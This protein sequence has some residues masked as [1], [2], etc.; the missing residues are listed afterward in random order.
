MHHAGLHG[1]LGPG[2]HDGV[3][4]PFEAVAAGDQHI[5]HAAVLQLGQHP[6][7]DLGAF[8]T[9]RA[10]PHPEHVAFPVDADAHCHVDRTVGDLAVADP[11]E[12]GVDQQDRVDRVQRPGLPFGHLGQHRVGH[13]GDQILGD[14][15]AVHVLQV[16][17][18]VAGRHALGVQ[19][20]HLLVEARQPAGML[21]RSTG[22]R[23]GSKVPAR[24]LGTRIWMSPTSVLT[25][26]AE[27]P[28]RMLPPTP[29]TPPCS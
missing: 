28:L 17:H 4:E 2:R 13:G 12:D 22:T 29:G 7:P 21:A 10:D 3:R 27:E 5:L 24:S 9:G 8:P 6:Q 14:L 18:D 25:V 23:T 15:R 19:A 11:H 16:R 26:L 20:D 1:G